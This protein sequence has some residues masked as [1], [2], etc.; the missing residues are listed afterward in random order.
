MPR[1]ATDFTHGL[2]LA[3]FREIFLRELVSNANDALEKLRITALREPGLADGGDLNITI[4]AIP[5]EEGTGGKLI[6]SGA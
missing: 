5:D 6:I 1:Q 4:K 2:N 3:A